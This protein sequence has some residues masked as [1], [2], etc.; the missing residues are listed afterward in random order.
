M[1][2]AND[3][4]YI[5]SKNITYDEEK[6]IIE[7]AKNSKININKT[8]ILIDR[9]IIDYN[10]NIIEV[11]GNFFLY[12][13]LNMLSGRDLKGNTK[14]DIFSA[15][16]VS[17][18][19]NNDLKIDSTKLNREQN[20]VNFY[21]NFI[22]PCEL[23]GFFNCPTWSLRIDKTEYNIEEDKFTHFD[24]FFQIADYKVFYLPY[25]THYGAK[26]PRQKGFLT[27]SIEF[28]IGGE[29]GLIL[30]Y[31]YPLNES[32]DITIK[33]KLYFDENFQFIENFDLKTLYNRRSLGGVVDIEIDNIKRENNSNVSNSI[34][35][36]TK[37]VIDK[38]KV[39][40]AS[41]LFTNSIST[42]R[43][44][45][46]EPITFEDLYLRL[47]NY[48]FFSNNDYLKTEL[49]SVESFDTKDS[50]SIPISP[51]LSYL[52]KIEY[53]NSSLINDIDFTILKR[54]NSDNDNPSESLK[55]N[56][57][58]EIINNNSLNY[59]NVFNKIKISNSFNE[60]TYNNNSNLNN[61]SIKSYGVMSSDLFF[62]NFKIT[63]PR[64]KTILPFQFTNT[65]KSVNEDSNALTFNY[66][67]QFSENRNFGNDLF[68]S[69][70]RIVYGIENQLRLKEYNFALNINQSYDTKKEN[71]YIDLLNQNSQFSDYAIEAKISYKDILFKLD[72]RID[73]K[74][75]DK[76]EMNYSISINNPF[77]LV[78]NYNETQ[79]GAFK[80]LSN[81]TQAI[82]F[83]LS[84][85]INKNISAY[86]TTNLDVKNNYD[87][88]QSTLK[89]SIFDECSQFDLTYSNTRFNDNFN[90]QPKETVGISFTMDYLGFFGYEQTTDLF[91]S[92]PGDINYGL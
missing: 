57:G 71:A 83:S 78:L 38:N 58:N 45:N 77:D 21:D 70:P 4:T 22:T 19:Y 18:I 37:N 3:D 7:L 74:N 63:T 1:L 25:F 80:N 61:T 43:S 27:P 49:S 42:T 87:P 41:G 28:T 84:K 47:E 44:I 13:E 59:F 14:L 23:E 62:N 54:N 17:Y 76:K 26:A 8:N 51:S 85:K 81:D 75:I 2:N 35:L 16:D 72:T 90:T 89:L 91:F 79:S 68:D 34:K 60:Y 48:N 29:Q 40:S 32:N 36:N 66:H 30:P 67:N 64:V 9:G 46:E 12:E 65:E 5:N 20:I 50:S 88:Y 11:Y 86:Y 92:Q 10:K 31:Y 69:S 73:Q 39:F 53:K 24:T 15:S 33:P 82:D 6:N 56:I 52:N 55:L